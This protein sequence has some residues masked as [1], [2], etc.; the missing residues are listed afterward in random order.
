MA[1]RRGRTKVTSSETAGELGPLLKEMDK[2]YGTGVVKKGTDIIQPERISTGVF[3]LDYC[4]LGGIPTSR[5][6]M[7]LGHKH[8]GKTTVACIIAGNAQRQFPGMKVAYVD[9][10]G[11]LDT[12]WAEKHGVNL[13]DLIVVH[14]ETGEAA[15][16]IVDALV[17]TKE[18]SVVVIDS[19]AALA[20]M[21]E[22]EGS[23]EDAHV[24]LQARLMGGLLRKT[25]AGMI[26][27]RRRGHMVTPIYINQYRSKIGGFQ[28]FGEPLSVPGG[29]ALGFAN[30]VEVVIKN[31][32]TAGKDAH[33]IEVMAFNEHAFKIEKNKLNGGSRVGEFRMVRTFDEETG[34]DE[35]AIDDAATML[36]FAKKY[37][38]YEGGGSSWTLH[39][40]DEE[41]KFRGVADAVTS[42][43]QDGDL[44]QKLRDYLIWE[45]ATGLKQTE[46]FCARFTSPY[47]IDV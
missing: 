37:G 36:A 12:V 9:I 15:A 40:W 6:T 47:G 26:A 13:D 38:A 8:S 10:E 1:E 22:I 31:K 7:L 44:Y 29:K 3:L 32:E 21:A 41:R 39:F 45:N 4:L 33:G 28:K 11:T 18:I 27:E 17:R 35:G 20:P 42:L 23:A 43:Y 2:R 14:P 46:E 16:D 5:G 30:S 34:L 25:T 24:G 19:V